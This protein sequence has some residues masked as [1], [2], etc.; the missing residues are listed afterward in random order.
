[1]AELDR[2]FYNIEDVA[3]LWHCSYDTVRSLIRRGKLRAFKVGTRWQVSETALAEC[4]A[5]LEEE[6]GR[7][8]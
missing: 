3:K 6:G 2:L 8:V 7:K 4:Q 1:M 5:L